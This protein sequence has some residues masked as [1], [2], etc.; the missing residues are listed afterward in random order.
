[1]FLNVVVIDRLRWLFSRGRADKSAKVRFAIPFVLYI[2]S[3]HHKLA[4]PI[5]CPLKN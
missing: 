3:S 1:M 2:I 5:K 4:Q